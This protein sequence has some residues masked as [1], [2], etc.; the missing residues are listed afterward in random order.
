LSNVSAAIDGLWENEKE[1]EE[2]IFRI[3]FITSALRVT[4]PVLDKKTFF[5][6][7]SPT[8]KSHIPWLLVILFVLKMSFDNGLRG[9]DARSIICDI[10]FIGENYDCLMEEWQRDPHPLLHRLWM[11]VEEE[12]E[13]KRCDNPA[14]LAPF[15]ACL[16][17]YLFPWE[18]KH[19]CPSCGGSHQGQKGDSP[20]REYQFKVSCK[21]ERDNSPSAM[22]PEEGWA[23]FGFRIK[24]VRSYA[25]LQPICKRNNGDEF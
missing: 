4:C 21:K 16:R 17:E 6:F 3:R 13:K 2:E 8:V 9:F 25:T 11:R 22:T 23:I 15:I 1:R 19:A 7:G 18:C 14:E 10:T 5:C 12:Y 20:L 24:V